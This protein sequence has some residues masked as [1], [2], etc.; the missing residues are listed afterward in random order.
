MKPWMANSLRVGAAIGCTAFQATILPWAS[1]A[2]VKPDLPLLVAVIMG[3]SHGSVSG[4]K[5]GVLLGMCVDGVSLA[6]F[7]IHTML[8]SLGGG[9]AGLVQSHVNKQYLLVPAI[10]FLVIQAIYMLLFSFIQVLVYPAYILHSA[11]V[12]NGLKGA[13]YG[14]C[15]APLFYRGYQ[16]LRERQTQNQWRRR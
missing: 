1:I 6:P 9:L 2:G 11:I 3:L 5:W 15:L 13:M 12:W 16:W 4:M 10:I 7:G 8:T 14:A